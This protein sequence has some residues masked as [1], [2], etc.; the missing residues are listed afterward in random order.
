MYP[1]S[2]I[3]LINTNGILNWSSTNLA[4]QIFVSIWTLFRVW[5]ALPGCICRKIDLCDL[6]LVSLVIMMRLRL[7]EIGMKI[8]QKHDGVHHN[9]LPQDQYLVHPACSR[10]K[11]S[12]GQQPFCTDH[13]QSSKSN[14]YLVVSLYHF[15]TIVFWKHITDWFLFFR[16]WWQSLQTILST[17]MTQNNMSNVINSYMVGLACPRY[18]FHLLLNVLV[19][20]N[21]WDHSWV[22][23]F[24]WLLIVSANLY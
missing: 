3:L 14:L 15:W 1:T 5:I 13:R 12:T 22:L 7:R 8:C 10:N 19:T 6:Y 20:R 9:L 2:I 17:I 4:K 24:R 18:N 23:S 16:Y 11:G 21:Y